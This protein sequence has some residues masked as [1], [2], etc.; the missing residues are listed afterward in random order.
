[1]SFPIA[2]KMKNTLRSYLAWVEK[3][4]MALLGQA[5][6]NGKSEVLG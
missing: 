3:V 4:E 6:S 1:M 2:N 5:R